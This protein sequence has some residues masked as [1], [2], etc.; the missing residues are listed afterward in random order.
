MLSKDGVASEETG[1]ERIVMGLFPVGVAERQHGR[2]VD[3]AEETEIS[4]VGFR[5]FQDKDDFF[6]EAVYLC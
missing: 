4:R 2:L 1:E 6:A 3:E 5:G